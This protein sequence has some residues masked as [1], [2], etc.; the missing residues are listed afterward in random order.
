MA[1]GQTLPIDSG[2]S[3]LQMAQ[4]IFG[5]DVTVTGASYFGDN[6]SSGI[7]SNGD[8][9]SPDVTPGDS[10]VILSTGFVRN[11][12]QPGGDPNRSDGTSTNTNGPRQP[13]RF[14]TNLGARHTFG[15]IGAAGRSFT[16]TTTSSCS[17][18]FASR[19]IPTEFTGVAVQTT[20]WDLDNG[21]LVTSHR[22]NVTLI[23]FRSNQSGTVTLFID[24]PPAHVLQTE[25]ATGSP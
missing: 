16:P 5:P 19:G 11:F 12:T 15:R 20:W 14:F 4:T 8:A 13:V 21:Q 22:R 9:V 18:T 23:Q 7:Y 6:R 24:I 2:A 17:F 3:A 25:I 10:G 1:T